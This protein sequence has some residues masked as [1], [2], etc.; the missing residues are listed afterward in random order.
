MSD[1]T[2]S[3]DDE[4][5]STVTRAGRLAIALAIGMT[6]G[7]VGLA[8]YA[9][10]ARVPAGQTATYLAPAGHL[11]LVSL[12]GVLIAAAATGCSA[13]G[14]SPASTLPGMPRCCSLRSSPSRPTGSSPPSPRN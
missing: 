12:I 4:R 11:L 7:A 10:V 9:Y 5:E 1:V 2:D 3:A 13:P 8:G 14:P 6:V